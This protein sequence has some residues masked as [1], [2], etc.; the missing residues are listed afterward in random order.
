MTKTWQNII[1]IIEP[2]NE[3]WVFPSKIGN[4]YINRF[5]IDEDAAFELLGIYYLSNELVITKTQSG[6]RKRKSQES[7]AYDLKTLTNAIQNASKFGQNS[8][9][10]LVMSL[11]FSF[12][13]GYI[14][15]IARVMTKYQMDRIMI[16]KLK[17]H[18]ENLITKEIMQKYY[19]GQS[20]TDMDKYSGSDTRFLRLWTL[21]RLSAELWYRRR[22]T[23][24]IKAT[25]SQRSLHKSV[26][27]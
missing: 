17:M 1:L 22:S 15:E 24:N 2:P 14:P 3:P 10:H 5:T 16:T 19:K 8:E 13:Y 7:R 27:L 18:R 26:S 23:K 11:D 21:T 9:T 6:I 4:S 20:S 12:R 25:F